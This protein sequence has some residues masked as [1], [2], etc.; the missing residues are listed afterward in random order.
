MDKPLLFKVSYYGRFGYIVLSLIPLF[1]SLFLIIPYSEAEKLPYL[2]SI[3]FLLLTIGNFG[4]T[5]Y[6]L[7]Q[8]FRISPRFIATKEALKFNGLLKSKELNWKYIIG[9]KGRVS[10]K[11]GLSSI[12]IEY[13]DNVTG[14]RKK[15]FADTNGMCPEHNELCSTIGYYISRQRFKNSVARY[16]VGRSC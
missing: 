11:F 16:R 9:C 14:K 12:Q 13:I 7:S 15:L 8:A 2:M 6:L 3:L 5:G 1:G 4:F 10:Y